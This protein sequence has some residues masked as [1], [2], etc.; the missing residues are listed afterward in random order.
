MV[1][2]AGLLRRS[3]YGPCHEVLYLGAEVGVV[4]YPDG[5]E[6]SILL[7]IIVDVRRG[8]SINFL[9]NSLI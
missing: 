7:K 6:D 4:R 3:S 8:A 5:V 2:D 9:L 1:E